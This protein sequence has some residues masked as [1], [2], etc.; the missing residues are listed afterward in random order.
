MSGQRSSGGGRIGLSEYTAQRL[1][2]LRARRAE[3][4][5][6][7][8]QGGTTTGSPA[9]IPPQLPAPPTTVSSSPSSSS[10]YLSSSTAVGVQSTQQPP[11]LP[12]PSFAWNNPTRHGN[13]V[14]QTSGGGLSRSSVVNGDFPPAVDPPS[15]R[16]RP[17]DCA[18]DT[19]AA[20]AVV[21]TR[22]TEPA[23]PVP[24]AAPKRSTTTSTTASNARSVAAEVSNGFAA[25]PAPAVAVRTQQSP[26]S[27]VSGGGG[28]G[29]KKPGV[30]R[31]SPSP[32]HSRSGPEVGWHRRNLL[33]YASALWARATPSPHYIFE[34]LR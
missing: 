5:A 3:V 31:Y 32:S 23:P 24:A 6:D 7:F 9:A 29:E 28:G 26:S 34:K 19:A 12:K 10:S 22:P 30:P 1:A 20:A 17:L 18:V 11:K 4:E 25:A 8:K 2:E 13:E 16:R 27:A 21:V 15:V 33:C 14:T